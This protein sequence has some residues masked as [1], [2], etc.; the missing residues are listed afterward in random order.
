MTGTTEDT[1]LRETATAKIPQLFPDA[2]YEKLVP[3]A[4]SPIFNYK[5]FHPSYNVLKKGHVRYPGRKAFE[6]DVVYDRDTAITVR[7]GVILYADVFRPLTSDKEPVPVIIPYSPY[8]K[9]G[10][11]PQNYD[12]MAPHRAGISLD[13]TSGYEK[14]EV[15]RR[16]RKAMARSCRLTSMSG[17]RPSRVVRAR[18]CTLEH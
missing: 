18:I 5:G 1:P 12:F 8:G 17:P 3:A 11:G 6:L 2:I 10:T 16:D 9:T 4:E 7:D 15:R 14:F 13:R